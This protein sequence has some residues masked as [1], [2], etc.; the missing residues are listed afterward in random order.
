MQ[1][2]SKGIDPFKMFRRS[3]QPGAASESGIMA[4]TD[5]EFALFQSLI[6]RESGIHLTDAKKPLLVGRLSRR[7]R[8]LGL[9]S[10]SAYYRRV[11]RGDGSDAERRFMVDCICTNETQFFRE[12]RQFEFLETRIIPEWKAQAASRQRSRR[13]RVWSSACSTGEEPF[14]LA[15]MLLYHLP[16]EAGWEIEILATDLSQRALESARAAVWP[17]EKARQISPQ[18][19]KAFMLQGTR[20][21]QGKMKAGPEIRYV[22][23]F[24]RVNLNDEVYPVDG[25]FDL[26]LCRNV[27][28]YFNADSKAHVMERLLSRLLPEGYLFLGHA[29]S[30][31]GM[32]AHVQSVGPTI[33]VRPKNAGTAYPLI[34]DKNRPGA[35]RVPAQA[36]DPGRRKHQG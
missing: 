22:T 12:A 9:S 32:G 8:E 23:T 18:F 34:A 17:V 31:S 4:I 36:D 33:Y 19:L 5:H 14:S 6:N 25:L 24:E 20:T 29:E 7:L 11:V 2:D 13:V 1:R 28:I 3:Q 10:F 26:I 15:M 35:M 21:Q 16:A 30:L 27:L